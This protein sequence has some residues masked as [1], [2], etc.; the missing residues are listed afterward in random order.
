MQNPLKE[1]LDT[2]IKDA[3]SIKERQAQPRTLF[4]RNELEASDPQEIIFPPTYARKDSKEGNLYDINKTPDDKLRC[5]LDSVGSQGNRLAQFFIDP[6][7][8]GLVPNVILDAGDKGLIHISQVTHRAADGAIT[9]SDG[10]AEFHQ[11]FEAFL[12]GNALPLANLD[13][14]SFVFGVWD[15]RSTLVRFMRTV[16]STINAF[17]V[18]A[19]K[20]ST[21]FTPTVDCA[22]TDLQKELAGGKEEVDDK[23]PLAQIGLLGAPSIDKHGGIQV[24][25]DILHLVHISLINIRQLNVPDDA[26]KTLALRRYILALS[27]LVVLGYDDYNLRSGCQLFRKDSRI[28]LLPGRTPVTLDVDEVLNYAR[29]TAKEFGVTT[30]MKKF[31]FSMELAKQLADAKQDKSSKKKADKKAAAAA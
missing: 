14:L 24:N 20:R 3:S 22:G 10:A 15:S 29:Q 13:P 6:L 17:D 2:W 26:A 16:D 11:A 27:L 30:A 9:A 28:E 18:S 12:A 23:H 25:G 4:I 1:T 7:A 8:K 21:Q 19:G 5:T 31:T